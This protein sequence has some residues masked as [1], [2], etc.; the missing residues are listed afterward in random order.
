M[1]E[2]TQ[3]SIVGRTLIRKSIVGR[4]RPNLQDAMQKAHTID[5]ITGFSIFLFWKIYCRSKI[6]QN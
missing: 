6:Y 4:N 5:V 2:E 1:A 3:A